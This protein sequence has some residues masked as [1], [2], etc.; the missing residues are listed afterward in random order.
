MDDPEYE[1]RKENKKIIIIPFEIEPDILTE[2]RRPESVK[3]NG[4]RQPF[5]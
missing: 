3:V 4:P 2:I 5:D 1:H